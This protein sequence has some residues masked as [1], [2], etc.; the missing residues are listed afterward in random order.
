MKTAIEYLLFNSGISNYQI[1]KATGISQVVL[2][3]YTNHV[4]DIGN[5]SLDT[6]IKLNNYFKE[7]L[8]MSEKRYG[9]VESDGKFYTVTTDAVTTN[10]VLNNGQD[11]NDK[12]DG[13][14][15]EFE[16]SADA[17]DPEGNGYI[18]YWVFEDVKGDGGKE[19]LDLFD[20]DVVNRVVEK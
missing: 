17:I 12:G 10:R 3:K 19:S 13:E 7:M 14:I 9:T 1:S 20:Y 4:S 16:M 8:K 6:A 5:M 11:Y 18:V 15:Y 2:G